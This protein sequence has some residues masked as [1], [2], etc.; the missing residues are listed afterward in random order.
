MISLAF[1]SAPAPVGS[2]KWSA[3]KCTSAY[4]PPLH[5]HQGASTKQIGSEL[6]GLERAHDC[7]FGAE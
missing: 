3:T 1:A 2:S 5:S 7:A 4:K 6:G